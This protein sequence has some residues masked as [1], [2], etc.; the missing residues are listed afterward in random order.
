MTTLNFQVLPL[1]F[2]PAFPVC[3]PPLSRGK[4]GRLGT[5][6]IDDQWWPV[7]VRGNWSSD[8]PCAVAG[9][10]SHSIAVTQ[11]GVAYTWGCGSE[12][13]LGTG[14]RSDSLLPVEVRYSVRSLSFQQPEK[15]S[16]SPM[17]AFLP[18]GS[19]GNSDAGGGG[20]G[21]NRSGGNDEMLES[22]EDYDSSAIEKKWRWKTSYAD[23]CIGR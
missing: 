14:C 5:G 12:G 3:I 8:S 21:K 13:R 23:A 11:G 6:S 20:H 7:V 22:S 2:S 16:S 15:A 4:C 17:S 9:G 18:V 19:S 1:V 10:W